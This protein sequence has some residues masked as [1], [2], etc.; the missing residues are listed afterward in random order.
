MK[1]Q[2][3]DNCFNNQFIKFLIIGLLSFLLLGCQQIND[4]AN[5]NTTANSNTAANSNTNAN[6]NASVEQANSSTNASNQSNIAAANTPTEVKTEA[7]KAF[8]NKLTGTWQSGNLKIIFASNGKGP[9]YTNG[10]LSFNFFYRIIY[11]ENVELSLERFEK[12][13]AK[14]T[15]EDDNKTLVWTSPRGVGKF[16]RESE[17]ADADVDN[18]LRNKIVGNWVGIAGTNSENERISVHG[19]GTYPLWDT[20]KNNQGWDSLSISGADGETLKF[21]NGVT[22]KTS[23]DGD[24]LTT[25]EKGVIKKYNRLNKVW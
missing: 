25:D 24:V 21:T 6:S 4:L 19:D 20:S 23:V 5:S 16:K 10:V 11:A 12:L 2:L 14:M 22:Y 9:Y 8:E 15:F 17:K 13:S 1:K 18:S 3:K 7:V